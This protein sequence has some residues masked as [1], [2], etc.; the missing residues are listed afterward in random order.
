M[1]TDVT[2]R[3]DATPTQHGSA[4]GHDEAASA[5]ESVADRA[6]AVADRAGAALDRTIADARPIVAQAGSAL[7]ESTRAVGT[8]SDDNL[9][10][11]TAT[12]TG[13]TIGLLVGGSNRLV[14]AGAL[15]P[16]TFMGYTLL[17]R[18]S[19]RNREG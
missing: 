6:G 9:V 19:H 15:L 16:A 5:L 14:V 3:S 4:D 2:R 10:I 1:T 17:A 12:L 18:F 13:L 8:S 7:A 11:G